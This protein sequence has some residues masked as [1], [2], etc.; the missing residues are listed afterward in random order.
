MQ[1]VLLQ[2]NDIIQFGTEDEEV[3]RESVVIVQVQLHNNQQQPPY[4]VRHD[5]DHSPPIYSKVHRHSVSSSSQNSQQTTTSKAPLVDAQMSCQQR[6]TDV[7]RKLSTLGMQL[8]GKMALVGDQAVMSERLRALEDAVEG[9]LS[10]V[11]VVGEREESFETIH[12]RPSL[13][14]AMNIIVQSLFCY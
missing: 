7:M 2:E 9:C 12:T 5:P 11:T 6:L 8:T 3:A 10:D 14:S 1:P 13:R 4:N